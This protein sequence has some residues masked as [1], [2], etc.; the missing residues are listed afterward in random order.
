MQGTKKCRHCKTEID[1]KANTCPQCRKKQMGPGA[2]VAVIIITLGLFGMIL[3]QQEDPKLVGTGGSPNTT[4]IV[5]KTTFSV[6]ETVELKNIKVAFKGISQ[7]KGTDFIKPSEGNIFVLCEFDIQ[8]S[9]DKDITVSSL[10]SFEAY[11]DDYATSIS[12]TA[13]AG[14]G[15]KNQLDGS[16]AAGKRMN[17]VIGYEVPA[18]WKELEIS[19]TPDFWTGK[20]ITFIATK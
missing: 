7:S 10:L 4:P 11:C 16:V 14:K 2:I 17:G 12:L 1:R 19:F 6:G 9:S 8:N 18:N 15:E 3:N 5:D 13:L 20:D